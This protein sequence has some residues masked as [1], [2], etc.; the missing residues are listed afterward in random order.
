MV[1]TQRSETARAAI[2]AATRELLSTKGY[3]PPTVRSVAESAGVDPAMVIRYYGS[4]EDLIAEAMD[5]HVDIPDPRNWPDHQIGARLATHFVSSWESMRSPKRMI[6]L[7]RSV[8]GHRAA[9]GAIRRVVHV[10]ITGF[11]RQVVGDRPDVSRRAGLIASH[12]LGIA[13]CRYVL[14]LPPIVALDRDALVAEMA[15]VLQRHLTVG[16]SQP[17]PGRGADM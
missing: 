4:K 3:G 10:Q 8:G 2:L 7:L 13:L 17:W 9:E 16:S 15:P 6:M 1:F 14:E 5:V 11:V 12:I